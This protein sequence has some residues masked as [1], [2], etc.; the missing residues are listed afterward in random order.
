[1][2]ACIPGKLKILSFNKLFYP[3]N[4]FLANLVI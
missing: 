1:M 2:T 3:G 4:S